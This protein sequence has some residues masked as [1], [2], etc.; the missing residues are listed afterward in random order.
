LKQFIVG[1]L[2][3]VLLLAACTPTPGAGT[4]G[5]KSSSSP[6]AKASN[7]P[8]TKASSSPAAAAEGAITASLKIEG[9]DVPLDPGTATF[10]PTDLIGKRMRMGVLIGKE[11]PSQKGE[12]NV[13]FL[14]AMSTGMLPGWDVEDSGTVFS[15]QVFYVNPDTNAGTTYNLSTNTTKQVKVT[16]EAKDNHIRGHYE[17]EAFAITGTSSSQ[18]VPRVPVVLDFDITQPPL[19]SAF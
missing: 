11:M 19:K 1:S 9:K 14:F 4:P 6:D 17:V 5:S 8:D 7:T 15:I 3:G 12:A 18:A 13:S 2:A 10:T 16:R